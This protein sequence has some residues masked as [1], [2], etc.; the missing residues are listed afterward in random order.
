MMDHTLLQI[1]RD[2]KKYY[3][4]RRML[5]E[6]SVDPHTLSLL[7]AYDQYFVLEP[8]CYNIPIEDGFKTWFYLSKGPKLT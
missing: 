2:R 8:D 6:K 4:L 1:M 5:N 3:Q 7:K